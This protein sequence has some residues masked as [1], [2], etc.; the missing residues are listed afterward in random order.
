MGRGDVRNFATEEKRTKQ[1]PLWAAGEKRRNKALMTFEE[2]VVV[3]GERN[4]PRR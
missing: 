3:G 2:C 4:S 1:K